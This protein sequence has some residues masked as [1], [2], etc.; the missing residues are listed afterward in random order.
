MRGLTA[1]SKDSGAHALRSK[2]GKGAHRASEASGAVSERGGPDDGVPPGR[3]GASC[4]EGGLGPLLPQFAM[5]SPEQLIA[6][7]RQGLLFPS[8][9]TL[10]YGA[11]VLT[12]RRFD[13][14]LQFTEV[15]AH[16]SLGPPVP[17]DPPWS[18]GE[19]RPSCE[20][21]GALVRSP[22]GGSARFPS[23]TSTP[24]TG[25]IPQVGR[26]VLGSLRSMAASSSPERTLRRSCTRCSA[27]RWM[28]VDL[29]WGS[30]GPRRPFVRTVAPTAIHRSR[31]VP[32]VAPRPRSHLLVSR[33]TPGSGEPR[34]RG[35][36]P[37]P[38]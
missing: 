7:P 27:R 15:G 28:D 18:G 14:Y 23:R 6:W 38:P 33:A 32:Y 13:F 4:L 3:A 20:V 22:P 31:S 25:S 11:A 12:D 24:S 34:L 37:R 36:D 16:S 1:G 21:A 2:G 29:S 10:A 30:S 35:W 26:G 17:G 9:E 19:V 8:A 5:M